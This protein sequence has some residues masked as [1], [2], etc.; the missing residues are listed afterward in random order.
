MAVRRP[1]IAAAL[2]LAAL[3]VM[4]AVFFRIYTQALFALV[5]VAAALKARESSRRPVQ[6]I[7]VA[8]AIQG[9]LVLA[10]LL[11]GGE[12][13]SAGETTLA[14]LLVL[15]AAGTTVLAWRDIRRRT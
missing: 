5:L 1:L 9:L 14:V 13:I 11:F 7:A 4:D 6:V 12:N 3:G 10:F 15:A 2:S 8:G